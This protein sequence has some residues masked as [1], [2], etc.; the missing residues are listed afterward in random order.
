MDPTKKDLLI[1]VGNGNKA[2]TN[3]NTPKLFIINKRLPETITNNPE[4]KRR[5]NNGFD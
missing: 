3:N 5:F 1:F 4:I 2:K